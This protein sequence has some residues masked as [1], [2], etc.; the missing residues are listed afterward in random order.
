MNVFGKI[1]VVLNL[2]VALATLAFFVVTKARPVNWVERTQDLT[3]QLEI[4][5]LESKSKDQPLKELMQE[6]KNYQNDV[7]NEANKVELVKADYEEKLN[8]LKADLLQLE[9]LVTTADVNKKIA[10]EEARKTRVEVKALADA[11]RTSE[12]AQLDAQKEVNK[13]RAQVAEYK[14]ESQR[15]ARKNDELTGIIRKMTEDLA[16]QTA[17]KGP[18]N[19]RGAKGP[20]EAN[21]PG[22]KVKGEITKVSRDAG[23]GA[24]LM[25]TVSVG[26]D[27]GASPNHTLDVYRLTPAPEYLGRL[28]ILSTTERDCVGRLITRGTANANLKTGDIVVDSIGN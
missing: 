19:A 1:L 27:Q 4:S 6:R 15:I 14:D 11:L 24:G 5:R 28:R 22:V 25:V 21:P 7:R 20:N 8:K 9:I 13:Y 2:V 10:E 18:G 12:Q 17:P 3:A 16:R 23:D 26:A